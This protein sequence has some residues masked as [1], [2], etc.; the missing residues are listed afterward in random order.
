MVQGHQN[1]ANG[2]LPAP[3]ANNPPPSRDLDQFKL[4]YDYIKFHIGLYLGT[5]AVM[6]IVAEPFSLKDAFLFRRGLIIM[7]FIFSISAGHAAWDFMGRYLTSE[8]WGADFP[9]SDQR[10]HILGLCRRIFHH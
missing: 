5:P 7:I 8:R 10:D 1:N 6:V 9:N 3:V 4:I 2:G